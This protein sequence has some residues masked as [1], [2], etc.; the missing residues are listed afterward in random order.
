MRSH[1]IDIDKARKRKTT[2]HKTKS[3]YASRSFSES[4]RKPADRSAGSDLEVAVVNPIAT[5]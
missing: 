2:K 1:G 4:K 3:L 5:P